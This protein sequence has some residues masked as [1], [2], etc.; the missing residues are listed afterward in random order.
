MVRSFDDTIASDGVSSIDSYRLFR[1]RTGAEVGACAATMEPTDPAGDLA[2][3][4]TP[5]HESEAQETNDSEA[6]EVEDTNPC[7]CEDAAEHYVTD[8]D[9]PFADEGGIQEW[10][11]R[12]WIWCNGYLP[13]VP[14]VL[15]GDETYL[16]GR[17]QMGDSWMDMPIRNLREIPDIPVGLRK[18]IDFLDPCHAMQTMSDLIYGYPILGPPVVAP[19]CPR[20]PRVEA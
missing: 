4:C 2:A 3:E 10:K 8:V 1:V 16:Q 6:E 17:R 9:L 19:R 14:A 12:S 11:T 18:L 15:D 5:T 13:D 7:D 20:A